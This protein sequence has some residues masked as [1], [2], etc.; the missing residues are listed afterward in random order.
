MYRK[1][2]RINSGKYSI[3]SRPFCCEA[4]IYRPLS[5]YVRGGV[6]IA[7]QD[8]RPPLPSVA[9]DADAPG[10][11]NLLTDA[12]VDRLDLA[13]LASQA[14]TVSERRALEKAA[15]EKIEKPE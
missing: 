10:E 15:R 7:G 5:F 12:T 2:Q 3:V 1:K 8:M 9:D 11:I 13:D 4:R 6:D 14:A